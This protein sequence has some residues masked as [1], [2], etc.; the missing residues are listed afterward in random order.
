MQRS[1]LGYNHA[2]AV[3]MLFLGGNVK[4]LKSSDI[5]P[6]SQNSRM[7]TGWKGAPNP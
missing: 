5:E 3:N 2:G 7:W 6:H 1:T 4:P